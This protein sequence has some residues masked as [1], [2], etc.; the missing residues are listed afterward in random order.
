MNRASKN[1]IFSRERFS[2]ASGKKSNGSLV[3]LEDGPFEENYR[4]QSIQEHE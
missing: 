3:M 2:E 1:N 4:H